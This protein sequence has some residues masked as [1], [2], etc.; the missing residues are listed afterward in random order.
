[1]AT[2]P[3]PFLFTW[4]EIEASSDLDRLRLVLAALPDEELVA[5]L[6]ARRGK[7]R[8]DYPIRPMWNALIAGI[9]FQH[10]SAASLLR[11]LSRNG[12]LRDL[13]GFD[14]VL[15]AATVPSDDAFGRFLAVVMDHQ[16]QLQAMFDELVDLLKQELPELGR[17]LAVDG[18]ALPSFGN[19]PRKNK[20][21]ED[22]SE[23][24][25][26][27]RDNDA[28]WGTKSYRGTRKDGSTWEK[29]SHWFGF[30]LHLLVDSTYELP[31][32]FEVTA[33]SRNDSPQML[34]LVEQLVQRHPQLAADAEVLTADKGYDSIANNRDPYADYGIKPVIDKRTLWK[35][36][37]T[38]RA[39]FDDR[40]DSFVYD[41]H[42]GVYCICP[43]TGEQR[44]LSFAGFEKDRDCLRYRCPAA[45]YGL[46]CKGRAQCES[47]AQV[48]PF[49][50]VI[51]VPL[52]KD[53]RI[54]TPIARSCHQW[55]KAYDAR[56]SVERVNGRIDCV[57]GFE[58]HTI[59]GAKKM[60]MRM[61]L[62]LVVMLAMAL[63]R[64]RAGQRDQ[65]RSFTTP[66]AA[67]QAA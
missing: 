64:I 10:E 5:L 53:W 16:E 65:L 21:E 59:R 8:N 31:L 57:L 44:D 33:A 42:G 30:K 39:L 23:E 40:A 62:A 27:R 46:D 15:G 28:D 22:N 43:Q 58:R 51:R 50:R 26:R 32:S 49:G 3:Q 12:E 6:E 19:P 60:K 67:A 36:G 61:T 24:P 2:I 34:P 55:K 25:D 47:N 14:P 17:R 11:E 9:V 4:K 1:M 63:G 18:K 66:V 48:G 52:E 35:D 29:V 13:C 7:G 41:E 56:S 45:A 38:T 54:F 37:E 20:S